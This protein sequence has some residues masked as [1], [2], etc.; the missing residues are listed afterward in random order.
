[1]INFNVFFL[2]FIFQVVQISGDL[3]DICETSSGEKGECIFVHRCQSAI[4]FI[5][6]GGAPELCGFEGTEALT[7]CE[8]NQLVIKTPSQATSSGISHQRVRRQSRHY[9][10]MNGQQV[11]VYSCSLNPRPVAPGTSAIVCEEK[12]PGPNMKPI[13]HPQRHPPQR[14]DS[15]RLPDGNRGECRALAQCPKAALLFTQGVHPVVCGRTGTEVYVCCETDTIPSTEVNLLG[16]PCV[17]PNGE[18]GN[19]LLPSSC[20]RENQWFPSV[21]CGT[22]KSEMICCRNTPYIGPPTPLTEINPYTAPELSTTES[23]PSTTTEIVSPTLQTPSTVRTTSTSATTQ[24]SFPSVVPR[25]TTDSPN[26]SNLRENDPCK[27]ST[28]ENGVCLYTFQC[29]AALEVILGGKVP[30]VC[31]RDGTETLICCKSNLTNP[32]EFEDRFAKNT[33]SQQKCIE[34]NEEVE[35]FTESKIVNRPPLVNGSPA[36]EKEFPQMG[37]TNFTKF[38]FHKFVIGGV[39]TIEKEFPHMAALGFGSINDVQ[40]LCGGSLISPNFILTAAHCTFTQELGQ[41]KFARMGLL[42]L[43]IITNNLQDF[44]ITQVFTHPDYRPP[45]QY[46]DIALLKLN[47]NADFTEYVKPACLY[48]SREEPKLKPYATGWGKT[49]FNGET[50]DALQKVDLNYFSYEQCRSAFASV[51]KRKLPNGI[52]DETQ[53][54]AGGINESKDTCQGDSGGPLQSKIEFG[55]NKPYYIIGVTSFGK[56]CGIPN[57]PAVYTRVSYYVPWIEQIV[58]P[59]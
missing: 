6:Q 31:G 28:G 17:F 7:C 50:S 29:T 39:K 21:Y 48:T 11:E 15:C 51:S 40:W 27:L 38:K 12:R 35:R 23:P 10:T 49:Q 19:C 53:V 3:G 25:E 54:C 13:V 46:N 43:K 32:F 41:V 55:L 14:H 59:E 8:R 57:T 37:N 52:V 58:W 26:S 30:D 42:N 16:R 33:V 34:Y 56:A 44:V 9:P 1:M 45:V 20:S 24:P 2:F 4:K 18:V 36:A 5:Q 47:K 22:S